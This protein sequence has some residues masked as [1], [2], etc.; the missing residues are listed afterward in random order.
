M[1]P[2]RLRPHHLPSCQPKLPQRPLL[3]LPRPPPLLMAPL[4][5]PRH[6]VHQARV[7]ALVAAFPVQDVVASVPD[8]AASAVLKVPE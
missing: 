3:R 7:S 5:P 6:P 8:A 2:P 1:P 4:Q